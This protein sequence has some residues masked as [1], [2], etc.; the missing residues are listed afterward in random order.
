MR[1][2]V[3][4]LRTDGTNCDEETKYAFELAGAEGCLVHVNQLLNGDIKLKSY[5][6]LVIPGGFSYGGYIRPGKI[7]AVELDAFLK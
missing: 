1:P 3:C 6:I 7:L 5:Q 2:K 4:V